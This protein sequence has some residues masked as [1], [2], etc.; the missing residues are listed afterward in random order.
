MNRFLT[1]TGTVSSPNQPEMDGYELMN[2]LR[3][4]DWGD[5]ES[6]VIVACSADWSSETEQ[7]CRNL[8]F[9][10][11]L[12]KPVSFS[13][14]KNFLAETANAVGLTSGESSSLIHY[15]P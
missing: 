12:R 9:D 13:D 1:P 3:D 8:G 15:T 5:R 14:L 7:R 6:P 2:N 4:Y 10:R 11:V